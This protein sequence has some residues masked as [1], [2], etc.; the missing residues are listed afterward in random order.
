MP[1]RKIKSGILARLLDEFLIQASAR[2]FKSTFRTG[3]ARPDKIGIA[4]ER[5]IGGKAG[6]SVIITNR[7]AALK[8]RQ[9]KN[10]I[11]VSSFVFQDQVKREYKVAST[12]DDIEPE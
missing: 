4:I 11:V 5:F 12:Q 1:A 2:F 8:N 7:L 6:E 3:G 9:Q 10:R